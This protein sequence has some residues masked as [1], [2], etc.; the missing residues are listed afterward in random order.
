MR[1]VQ[2]MMMVLLMVMFGSSQVLAQST[3]KGDNSSN[4]G[5]KT[6]TNDPTYLVLLGE[7]ETDWPR[8]LNLPF[9]AFIQDGML[10]VG[11]L[12]DLNDVTITLYHD[13]TVMFTQTRD[14]C[15]MDSLII[16]VGGYPS[17][18]YLLLITTPR[19]TYIYANFGL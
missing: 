12:S 4:N 8:T 3:N 5:N 16:P 9:E 19:G 7:S 17:G 10:T 1:K 15:F 6:P 2:F 18:N 11:S 13:E 14:F